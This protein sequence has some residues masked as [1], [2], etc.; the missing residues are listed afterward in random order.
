[1]RDIIWAIWGGVLSLSYPLK[2]QPVTAPGEKS[3]IS[4][5]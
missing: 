5:E 3:D 4:E 1:M 2:Q